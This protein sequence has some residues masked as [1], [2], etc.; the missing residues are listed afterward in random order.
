[1]KPAH[2]SSTIDPQIHHADPL[3]PVKLKEGVWYVNLA[4]IYA[5]KVLD[6]LYNNLL[7]RFVEDPP[8]FRR[9]LDGSNS[10]ISGS[11][12]VQFVDKDGGRQANDLD[13]YVGLNNVDGMIAFFA[14]NGYESVEDGHSSRGY[15][16]VHLLSRRTLAKGSQHVD[17]IESPTKCSLHPIAWFWSSA[18][19]NFMTGSHFCIAYP[20]ST[21]A[22]RSFV[23][24][25]RA[26]HPG[27]PM[28]R[29]KYERRGY[30]SIETQQY[31]GTGRSV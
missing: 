25:I 6:L 7:R 26:R 2:T 31:E 24:P 10:V 14:R 16:G 5:L 12:A 21:L 28:L 1:M 8:E 4:T 23:S 11:F 3:T 29:S 17:I 20:G 27:L 19:M 30:E 13:V 15:R 9:Y 22:R 18:V